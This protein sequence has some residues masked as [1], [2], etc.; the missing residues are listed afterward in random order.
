[1]CHENHT[2]LEEIKLRSSACFGSWPK[3]SILS[4]HVR[5]FNIFL[6][7]FRIPW[8]SVANSLG[9]WP[10]LVLTWIWVTPRYGPRVRVN[11]Y[12]FDPNPDQPPSFAGNPNPWPIS[13][14][15]PYLGV[16]HIQVSTSCGNLALSTSEGLSE[17]H[18]IKY[19]KLFKV[20]ITKRKVIGMLRKQRRGVGLPRESHVVGRMGSVLKSI[21]CL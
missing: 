9:D 5:W 16:T 21:G 18:I 15:D 3:S 12:F 19:G 11:L 1:M 14:C 2:L 8:A 7:M 20:K 13:R 4:F 6:C 17:S 10:I